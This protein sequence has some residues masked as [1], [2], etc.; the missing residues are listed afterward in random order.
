M[1]RIGTLFVYAGGPGSSGWDRVQS[2]ATSSPQEIRDRFDIVGFDP[3][4]VHRSQPVSCLDTR[5]YQAQWAQ[6]STPRAGALRHGGPA[7]P[8]VRRRLPSELR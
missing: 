7:R 8:A 5:T 3:R 2:F 6:V 4:G 1:N